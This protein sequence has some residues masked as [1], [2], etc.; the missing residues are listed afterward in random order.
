MLHASNNRPK[1][2]QLVAIGTGAQCSWAGTRGSQ[3]VGSVLESPGC[4]VNQFQ[5]YRV[6]AVSDCPR[7]SREAGCDQLVSEC[8]T[9]SPSCRRP[10]TRR[11]DGATLRLGGV[12]AE[13]EA[14]SRIPAFQNLCASVFSG[15]RPG[16]RQKV[17]P[18]IGHRALREAGCLE[19]TFA[20][21]HSPR[22]LSYPA[23]AE[24]IAPTFLGQLRGG[25]AG[26]SPGS[27][28]IQGDTPRYPP[29]SKSS[30]PSSQRPSSN[31]L[32]ESET[33]CPE[34]CQLYMKKD[35]VEK[36]T[37]RPRRRDQRGDEQVQ[38]TEYK[39]IDHGWLLIGLDLYPYILQSIVG[40]ILYHPSGHPFGLSPHS[41]VGYPVCPH[42]PK[43]VVHHHQIWWV[44]V[45][46]FS[47]LALL[48]KVHVIHR[49]LQWT[50]VTAAHIWHKMFM[51]SCSRMS[52]PHCSGCH[53]ASAT[54][55][56]WCV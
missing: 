49:L 33:Q 52:V 12:A 54:R 23:G 27:L 31:A 13:P 32:L 28:L 46:I 35:E 21:H 7:P 29:S 30:R 25:K 17:S 6:V 51:F 26:S 4:E 41:I 34:G 19:N 24:A 45:V 22:G 9:H 15:W 47:I 36:R 11:S 39:H 8:A 37:W 43:P 16:R 42:S 55:T 5:P 10:S 18:G 3:A 56:I 53:T 2:G 44:V 1:S 50:F 14:S 38:F 20:T 48:T 40:Q